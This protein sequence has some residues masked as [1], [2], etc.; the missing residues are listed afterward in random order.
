M[1][2]LCVEFTPPPASLCGRSGERRIGAPTPLCRGAVARFPALHL[3]AVFNASLGLEHRLRARDGYVDALSCAILGPPPFSAPL[4]DAFG[5]RLRTHGV[6][7]MA[8]V[9]ALCT[10]TVA[11]ASTASLFRRWLQHLLFRHVELPALPARCVDVGLV[12]ACPPGRTSRRAGGAK[13]VPSGMDWLGAC[14]G[15]GTT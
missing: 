13:P 11:R 9:P 1:P 5:H 8:C 3:V 4:G 15:E 10:W 7:A 12:R 14:P 6:L 2:H